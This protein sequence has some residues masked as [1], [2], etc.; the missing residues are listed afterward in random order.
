MDW[1]TNH[2][3]E[4]EWRIKLYGKATALQGAALMINILGIAWNTYELL[5]GHNISSFGLVAFISN[6]FWT[7]GFFAMNYGEWRDAKEQKKRLKEWDQEEQYKQAVQLHHE[8]KKK[9][10]EACETFKREKNAN[11]G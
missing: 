4:I 2:K 1:I 10:E 11:Q 5:A 7:L 9:Y 8:W 6:G 3:N